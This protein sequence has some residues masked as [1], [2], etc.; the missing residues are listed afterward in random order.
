M[1]LLTSYRK[2][3]AYYRHLGSAAMDQLTWEELVFD[4]AAATNS[5]AVIVKH[6]SGSSTT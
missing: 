6:L 5:I 3:F 2:Q 1:D 4:D